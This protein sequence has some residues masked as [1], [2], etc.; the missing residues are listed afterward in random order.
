ML[1]P[2]ILMTIVFVLIMLRPLPPRQGDY[3]FAT[4]LFGLFRLFYLIPICLVWMAYLAWLLWN[5]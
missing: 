5:K 1:G 4:P 3:D 2:C